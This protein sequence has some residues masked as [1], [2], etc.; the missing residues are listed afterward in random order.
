MPESIA[1][2]TKP[3]LAAEYISRYRARLNHY[4]VSM[5]IGLPGIGK[6]TL[7]RRIGGQ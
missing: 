5:Y 4:P 1:T 2:L 7:V 3:F 6:T